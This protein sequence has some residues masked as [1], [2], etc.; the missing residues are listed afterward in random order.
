[1]FASS[2]TQYKDITIQTYYS[3]KLNQNINLNIDTMGYSMQY[4]LNDNNLKY[5]KVTDKYEVKIKDEDK[6]KL[7]NGYLYEY[8]IIGTV[9]TR[10]IKLFFRTLEVFI[11]LKN[12]ED[13]EQQ[14]QL[15][16]F[17]GFDFVKKI[18]LVES[19]VDNK[20]IYAYAY[21]LENSSWTTPPN[22]LG[23]GDNAYT[24]YNKAYYDEI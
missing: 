18:D 10:K 17:I 1:M 16:H 5:N 7:A 6:D 19:N 12:I 11:I 8:N 2:P 13:V 3:V 21:L 20:K 4:I 24:M 22:V 9:V 23:E 14:K 15:K